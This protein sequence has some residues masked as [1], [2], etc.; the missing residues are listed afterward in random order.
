MNTFVVSI[1]N[2]LSIY[3]LSACPEAWNNFDTSLFYQHH[4]KLIRNFLICTTGLMTLI[5]RADKGA[6]S[7]QISL[8]RYFILSRHPLL[9]L[10][11]SNDLKQSQ[12]NS[13]LDYPWVISSTGPGVKI[14]K[15][16]LCLV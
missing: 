10:S 7:D 6:I 4:Q 15:L 5:N 13:V 8:R 14:V 2:L 9:L 11:T 1:R 16:L 12:N 3:N